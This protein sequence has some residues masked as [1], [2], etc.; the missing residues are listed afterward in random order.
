[1]ATR[2][3]YTEWIKF[4]FRH[5]RLRMVL[6]FSH[7]QGSNDPIRNSVPLKTQE[8]PTMLMAKG[9]FWFGAGTPGHKKAITRRESGGEGPSDGSEI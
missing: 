9:G 7:N 5:F 2:K 4:V 8:T 6:V 1:M 3:I